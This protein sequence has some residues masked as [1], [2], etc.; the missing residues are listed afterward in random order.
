VTSKQRNEPGPVMTLG[1]MRELG[2]HHLLA[3]ASMTLA[4]IRL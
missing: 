3:S 4:V 2:V 1:N